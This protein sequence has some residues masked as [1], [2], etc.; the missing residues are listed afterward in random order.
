[1]LI[2]KLTKYVKIEPNVGI[3]VF[4]G[5]NGFDVLKS[6][7]GPKTCLKIITSD[8]S[9]NPIEQQIRE[10]QATK[11]VFELQSTERFTQYMLKY[12]SSMCPSKWKTLDKSLTIS[13]CARA[14]YDDDGCLFFGAG[15]GS[16]AKSCALAGVS[17]SS[18]QKSSL[19]QYDIYK[20]VGQQEGEF[21]W[22]MQFAQCQESGAYLDAQKSKIVANGESCGIA[23][24]MSTGGNYFSWDEGLVP[25]FDGSGINKR[26][27][28]FEKD[29][30]CV[31]TNQCCP[32]NSKGNTCYEQ[33]GI[34][35]YET[36]RNECD[37]QKLGT[38]SI[39]ILLESMSSKAHALPC[40]AVNTFITSNMPT[41]GKYATAVALD[42]F[43]L[44]NKNG[45]CQFASFEVKTQNCYLLS[46]AITSIS[47]KV[48]WVVGAR[49]CT[50]KLEVVPESLYWDEAIFL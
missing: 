29:Y 27:K 21:K 45:E 26:C 41:I 42:C 28:C 12:S 22:F 3:R 5:N 33:Y 11:S 14:C 1:M 48:G 18:R 7:S 4:N 46:G 13:Q 2:G 10:L 16:K 9:L 25:Q 34:R 17:C 39:G 35:V 24:F 23:C 44:C 50:K 43:S 47:T 19:Q 8:T 49:D 15:K 20:I 30:E 31:P 32:S 37:L 38:E 36:I 40:P 6:I